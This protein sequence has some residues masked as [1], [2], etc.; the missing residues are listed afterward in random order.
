MNNNQ[1]KIPISK[2]KTVMMFIGSLLFVFMGVSFLGD[3]EKFQT[4]YRNYNPF[5]ISIVGVAS[6]I[7]FGFAAIILFKRLF[8]KKAGL[9]LDEEGIVYDTKSLIN[10]KIYWK[11]IDQ[12]SVYALFGQKFVIIKV[13]NPQEYIEKE[14]SSVKR[15]LLAFN[16]K[17]YESPFNITASGLQIS[18]DD[19]FS[20]LNSELGKRKLTNI[21]KVHGI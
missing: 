1:I 13:T 16:F 14:T 12:L 2:A 7:F 10:N 11:D 15:N 6:I 9:I 8:Q 5:F 19:L 18:F 21:I 3:P 20:L 4:T 17:N